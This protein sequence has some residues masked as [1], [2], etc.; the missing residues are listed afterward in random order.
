MN[1]EMGYKEAR[2]YLQNMRIFFAK[3][4]DPKLTKA[5]L[6]ADEALLSKIIEQEGNNGQV[7][8]RNFKQNG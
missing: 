8:Q 1:E 3:T 4:M 6:L 2:E 7:G 5:L